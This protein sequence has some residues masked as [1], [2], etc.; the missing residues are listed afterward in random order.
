MRI[1]HRSFKAFLLP[2]FAALMLLSACK[3]NSQGVTDLTL[4]GKIDKY[5]II[6]EISVWGHGTN[7]IG[8]F[9]YYKK[10]GPKNTI[11]VSEDQ[12][13]QNGD[14]QKPILQEIEKDG[15]ITGTFYAQ[16]WDGEVMHGTW[17]R[18]RDGKQMPFSLKVVKR[19]WHYI[20]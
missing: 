4:D 8:G 14:G 20:E 2:L 13:L 19:N 11:E 5:P 16:F 1:L 6:M 12:N 17:I 3:G 7:I 9:Y 18:S 10:N 15:K